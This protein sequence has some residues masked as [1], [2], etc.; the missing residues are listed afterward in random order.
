MSGISYHK[1]AID[2]TGNAQIFSCKQPNT[3]SD[4]HTDADVVREQM[5]RQ[6]KFAHSH[7]LPSPPPGSVA[8]EFTEK[9]SLK[10]LRITARIIFHTE[11][12][13]K[14]LHTKFSNS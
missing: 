4:I 8:K 13:S 5:Q 1:H 10:L 7:S 14:S 6:T 9:R 2:Q 3:Q 11:K 12:P